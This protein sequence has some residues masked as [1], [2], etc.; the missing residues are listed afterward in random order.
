MNFLPDNSLVGGLDFQHNWLNRKYFVDAKS[1][2]SKV[3]GSTYGNICICKQIQGIYFS[4][5]D[6]EHLEFNP[7]LTSLQ[8][9]GGEFSGGKRSGKFRLTGY[10]GL[11]LARC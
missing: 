2:F 3:N 6:A 9:W 4:V 5:H 7:D 8:G 1:F 11:A 10:I